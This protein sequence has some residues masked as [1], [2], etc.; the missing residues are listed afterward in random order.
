MLLSLFVSWSDFVIVEDEE[1]DEMEVEAEV[2]EEDAEEVVDEKEEVVVPEL[3][4]LLLASGVE[5]GNW[6]LV[7]S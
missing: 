3:G 5:L 2:E 4:A 7:S 6:G 1:E